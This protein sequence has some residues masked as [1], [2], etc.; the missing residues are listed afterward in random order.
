MLH[1]PPSLLPLAIILLS[2]AALLA[3]SLHDVMARTV[4]NGLALAIALL[5][6][7]AHLIDGHIVGALIAG[8]AVFIVAALC[9]RYRFMGGGDV[10]LLA[11][12]AVVVPPAAVLNFITAVALAG[13]VLALVY[14]FGRRFVPRPL[15]P[16]PAHLLGR[17]CRVEHWR[18]H[19]GG[20]LPYACAIA[21]G[22]LFI[23]L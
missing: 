23:L 4:P 18:I 1:N 10:K 15:A 19:R 13:G 2:A 5:G 6:L 9:W 11:A 12:T 17:V 14:L 20:P 3:A 7:I 22:G 16:R 21:A 8:L